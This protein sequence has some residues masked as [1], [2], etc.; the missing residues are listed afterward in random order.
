MAYDDERRVVKL[1]LAVDVDAQADELLAL[2]QVAVT[3]G[4]EEIL[5][6]GALVE[7]V[8]VAQH[9]ALDEGALLAELALE[10]VLAEHHGA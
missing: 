2:A 10:L 6:F 7:G 9:A 1:V 3:A 4:E 5:E 8:L